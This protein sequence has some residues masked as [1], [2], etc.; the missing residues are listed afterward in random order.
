MAFAADTIVVG[1]S[2]A[3][4][5]AGAVH[6]STS[7]GTGWS[8]LVTIHGGFAGEQLGADVSMSG[9]WLAIAAVGSGAGLIDLYYRNGMVWSWVDTVL[10]PLHHVFSISTMSVAIDGVWMA[11]A[12]HVPAT[13]EAVVGMYQ[14]DAGGWTYQQRIN[15]GVASDISLDLEDG[16][17]V[18]GLPT[19]IVPGST[20]ESGYVQIYEF[21]DVFQ[22][23]MGLQSF[24]PTGG[25]SWTRS[26]R[27]VAT[28]NGRIAYSIGG[29][30]DTGGLWPYPTIEF[31]DRV[32]EQ[33]HLRIRQQGVVRD[34]GG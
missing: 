9:N 28:Q 26:G 25:T 27:L 19:V 10:P 31:M 8:A 17:L 32:G 14:F 1:D 23:W 3:N 34:S 12:M 5:Y 33:F 7:D 18:V 15:F 4:G 21:S 30:Y 6:L 2:S 20:Y 24:Q 29:A 13:S 11:V 22:T 16:I